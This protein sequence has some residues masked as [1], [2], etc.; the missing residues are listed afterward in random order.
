METN[1]IYLNNIEYLV[2]KYIS[3]SVLA[4]IIYSGRKEEYMNDK[5]ILN[6][7]LNIFQSNL[8]MVLPD[9]GTAKRSAIAR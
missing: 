2:N 5:N 9:F 8:V 1:N 7:F 4:R 6:I 3:D